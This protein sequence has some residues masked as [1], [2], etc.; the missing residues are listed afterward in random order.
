MPLK[1]TPCLFVV[2]VCM[3]VNSMQIDECDGDNSSTK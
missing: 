2:N 1:D 3:H